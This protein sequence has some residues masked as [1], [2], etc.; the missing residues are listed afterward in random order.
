MYMHNYD[1]KTV[2]RKLPSRYGNVMDLFS[3]PVSTLRPFTSLPSLKMSTSYNTA[4][5][6]P[7]LPAVPLH[8]V[9]NS[10]GWSS[11]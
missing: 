5:E 3:Y 9:Q 7:E 10:A 1:A 11:C 8:E 6:W 4:S 2:T